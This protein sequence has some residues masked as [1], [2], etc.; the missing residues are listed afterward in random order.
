M[1]EWG[2][3]HVVNRLILKYALVCWLTVLKLKPLQRSMSCAAGVSN[4]CNAR[5]I[6]RH[7]SN[8][9][10]RKYLG[11]AFPDLIPTYTLHGPLLFECNHI[12]YTWTGRAWSHCLVIPFPY[13]LPIHPNLLTWPR[14]LVTGVVNVSTLRIE[15]WF[16]ER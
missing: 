1:S 2:H 16:N 13:Y 10:P 6:S 14:L 3:F 12:Q 5:R 11:Q 15:A 9:Y 8:A 4:T 7:S